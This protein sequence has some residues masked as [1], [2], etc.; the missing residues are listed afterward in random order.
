M[1]RHEPGHRIPRGARL[2]SLDLSMG[3]AFSRLCA[4]CSSEE[5]SAMIAEALSL[6]ADNFRLLTSRA[7]DCAPESARVA[8]GVPVGSSRW[9]VAILLT[10]AALSALSSAPATEP[11][12]VLFLHSFGRDFAPYATT[13]DAIRAELMRDSSCGSE[14]SSENGQ[15]SC[16]EESGSTS[17][18]G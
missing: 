9:A 14:S 10:L 16:A 17:S 18:S 3:C 1:N 12:R 2:R 7:P 13:V 15:P 6:D 8:G 5:Q 4:A 11:K